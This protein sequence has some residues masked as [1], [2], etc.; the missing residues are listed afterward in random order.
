M[1]EEILNE[2]ENN[3]NQ[4]N[5]QNSPKNTN[6]NQKDNWSPNTMPSPS[7]IK[8]NKPPRVINDHIVQQVYKIFYNLIK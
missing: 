8:D 7:Q 3:Q 2:I 1:E 4:L 5:N 6:I